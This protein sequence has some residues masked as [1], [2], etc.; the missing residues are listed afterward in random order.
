M[1]DDATNTEAVYEAMA[2]AI[3]AAGPERTELLLAKFALLLSEETRD[4]GKV[5]ALLSQAA[6]TLSPGRL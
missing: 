4:T 2:Q 6:A 3:D 5:L 1:T